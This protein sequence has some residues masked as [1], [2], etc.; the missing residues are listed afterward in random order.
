MVWTL[1]KGFSGLIKIC[2]S[3][4]YKSNGSGLNPLKT[5]LPRENL[6]LDSGLPKT[7]IILLFSVKLISNFAEVR[8]NEF[9]TLIIIN[10]WMIGQECFSTI[11]SF[12]EHRTGHV[13]FASTDVSKF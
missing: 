10:P 2:S 3:M 11:H 12:T 7:H 6:L 8:R 5:G 9:L 13:L 4:P 1:V